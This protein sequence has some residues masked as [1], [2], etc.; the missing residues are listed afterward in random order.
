MVLGAGGHAKVV[1]ATAR[2]A[3]FDVTAVLDDNPRLHGSRISEV[4]VTGFINASGLPVGVGAVL[5]IGS[6]PSRRAVAGR[7]GCK[8][9]TIIHPEARIDATVVVGEGT[10]VFAGVVVQPD[11]VI[12]AHTILNTSCSVDHDCR[13]GNYA[14]LAPGTHLAGS[15]SVEEG[16]FVGIGAVIVPGLRV[17]AW[18]VVGAGAVVTRDVAPGVTVVGVPARPLVP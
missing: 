18:A 6:N 12:G 7:I 16:G 8:W 4:P 13:V 5:A 3:G 9:A 1:I 10:V 15:C 17:G 14:H 2:A 11:T